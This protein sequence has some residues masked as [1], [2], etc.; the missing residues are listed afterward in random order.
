MTESSRSVKQL[1]QWEITWNSVN[2]ACNHPQVIGL[3]ESE[4]TVR[5]VSSL[6]VQPARL[7]I[8]LVSHQIAK[9]ACYSLYHKLNWRDIIAKI[10]FI[11]FKA[12]FDSVH[13]NSLWKILSGYGYDFKLRSVVRLQIK[14]FGV[15]R[16][17]ELP[18]N[19][20]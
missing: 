19:Y 14:R 6:L 7:W 3:F 16:N 13:R 4:F 9:S 11:D 15:V 1:K 20:H 17:V 8:Q 18:L 10:N 2:W 5:P 12:A